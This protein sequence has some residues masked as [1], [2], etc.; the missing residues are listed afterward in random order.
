MTSGFPGMRFNDS[1]LA[2][3]LPLLSKPYRKQDLIR[4]VRDVLDE[5][6][7]S[8]AGGTRGSVDSAEVPRKMRSTTG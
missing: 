7:A 8:K 5:R 1:E 4:M 2:K 6:Q 3:S